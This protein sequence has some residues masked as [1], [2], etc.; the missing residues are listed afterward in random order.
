M[1]HQIILS[2][3]GTKYVLQLIA[4]T[5]KSLRVWNVKFQDGAEAVLFKCGN[6]WMQRNED[7]LDHWLIKAIGEKIDQINPQISFS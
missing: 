4:S 1:K 3:N 2:G 7:N 6:E 5:L